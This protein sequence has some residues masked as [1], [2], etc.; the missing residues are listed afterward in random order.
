MVSYAFILVMDCLYLT[1][2]NIF[3]CISLFIF[4]FFLFCKKK[5]NVNHISGFTLDLTVKE[6]L[7]SYKQQIFILKDKFLSLV[8][9]I[10]LSLLHKKIRLLFYLEKTKFLFHQTSIVFV[11]I[12]FNHLCSFLNFAS[13]RI[14]LLIRY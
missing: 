3:L 9:T 5:K 12:A 10:P 2:K 11:V 14:L 13:V 6:V 7:I 4:L 1:R 8:S